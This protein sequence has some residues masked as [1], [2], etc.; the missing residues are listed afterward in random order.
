MKQRTAP[1]H[2]LKETYYEKHTVSVL[3]HLVIWTGRTQPVGFLFFFFLELP[4]SENI[5]QQAV[6]IH[7]PFRFHKESSFERYHPPPNPTEETDLWLAGRRGGVCAGSLSFNGTGAQTG[8]SEQG[9]LDRMTSVLYFSAAVFS[10]TPV[11]DFS[12]RPQGNV[13]ICGKGVECVTFN[14]QLSAEVWC[15]HG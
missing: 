15:R 4:I 13:S 12:W 2:T 8:R 10:P 5:L 6:Q 9:C 1:P 3:V 14:L 7:L 11:T